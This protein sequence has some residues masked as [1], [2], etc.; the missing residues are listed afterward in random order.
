MA[1]DLDADGIADRPYRPNGMVDRVMWRHPLAKL[2]LNSP[3][4]Q[5]LR[6]AQ[7]EFPALHPGGVIDRA[8]LMA[9]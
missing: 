3:A 9:P 7:A 4:A 8:P 2:L 1:F 6:W 5:I